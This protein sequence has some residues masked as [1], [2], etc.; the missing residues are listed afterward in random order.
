MKWAEDF[1]EWV[2]S[3]WQYFQDE[4]CEAESKWLYIPILHDQTRN[5]IRHEGGCA[6]KHLLS[7]AR[8]NVSLFRYI[9]EYYS[10]QPRSVPLPQPRCGPRVGVGR[11]SITSQ[12]GNANFVERGLTIPR[13]GVRSSRRE[14]QPDAIFRLQTFMC[15]GK[16]RK[17]ITQVAGGIKFVNRYYIGTYI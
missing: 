17:L 8:L 1:W 4:V 2:L 16:W 7:P 11:R 12:L 15:M 6:I 5:R 3:C 14:S 13:Y 9:T 10:L